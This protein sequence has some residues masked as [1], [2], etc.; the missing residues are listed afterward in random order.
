VSSSTVGDII[1]RA[2]EIAQT[3]DPDSEEEVV[4]WNW[5]EWRTEARRMHDEM[6]QRIG[7]VR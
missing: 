3:Y 7:L 1:D 4:I 5:D 2:I 6:M